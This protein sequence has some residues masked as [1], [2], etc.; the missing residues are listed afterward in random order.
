V[1][2]L[3]HEIDEA[4][5]RNDL[6]RAERARA[7][8]DTLVDHLTAALGLGGKARQQ[9]GTAERARSTVTHRIRAAV[10]Q[11]TAVHPP[12]GRH[13]Q[14]AVTTGLY[15]CYRPEVPVRWAP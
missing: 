4:D 6:A 11:I 5:D 8:L 13:L 15:C 1:R 12:L 3:Q 10:R 9:G 7:E 14:A 2:E